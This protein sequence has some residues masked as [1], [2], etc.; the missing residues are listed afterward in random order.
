[1]PQGRE[2]T[3]EPTLEMVMTLET[4]EFHPECFGGRPPARKKPPPGA[5]KGSD[6][7]DELG[8]GEGGDGFTPKSDSRPKR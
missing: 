7:S 1:M 4:L 3:T 6:F 2:S 5:Y 8:K